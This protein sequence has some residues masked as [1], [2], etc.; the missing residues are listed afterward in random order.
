MH[1][2][3]AFGNPYFVCTLAI[4]FRAFVDYPIIVA[5]NR[6]EHF[7]RPSSPPAVS[8]GSPAILAGR[9]LRVGG[10]W[11][12]VNEHG[13]IAAVLN[14][15]LNGEPLSPAE[16]RSRGLLCMDLLGQKSARSAKS[17]MEG[18]RQSYLPFTLVYGDPNELYASYNPNREIVTV[19]LEPGL[20]VF[21]SAAEFDLHSPKAARA[22]SLFAALGEKV[23]PRRD[24]ASQAVAALQS[25][26]AD[27][28]QGAN[29]TEPGDAICVHREGSGTVS[30]SVIFLSKA[31]SRF[32]VYYCPDAPCRSTFGS[33]LPL[34]LR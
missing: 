17:F 3:K 15:R 14:R 29:A 32:W 7:D 25:V 10:T 2:A 11:L 6:D 13:V 23:R 9:D 4:Y 16:V 24:D 34:S 19:A 33:A 1:N 21:S 31:A 5:A 8:E 28:S 30:S 26:L 12:G 20:H 22:H 27:H 18:H